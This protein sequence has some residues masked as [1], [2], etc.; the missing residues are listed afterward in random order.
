MNNVAAPTEAANHHAGE[1]DQKIDPSIATAITTGAGDHSQQASGN[2]A[3]AYTTAPG[4]G[5]ASSGPV[6]A[7]AEKSP[8]VPTTTTTTTT[9]ITTTTGAPNDESHSSPIPGTAPT[10]PIVGDSSIASGGGAG[11]GSNLTAAALPVNAGSPTT[12]NGSVV[13]PVEAQ[14]T[15]AISNGSA[16]PNANGTNGTNQAEHSAVPAAAAAAGAGAA[17]GAAAA[18]HSQEKSQPEMVMKPKEAKQYTK[19]LR[20][21]AKNDEKDLAKAIKDAQNL[22]KPLRKANKAEKQSEKRHQSAVHDEHKASKAFNKYKLEYEKAQ[23]AL[24]K[25]LDELDIKK[26]HTHATQE[27]FDKAKQRIDSLRNQ[28]IVNDKDRAR[29]QASITATE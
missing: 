15:S 13:S 5:E 4:T 23:A 18:Q 21:E 19:L 22:E 24:Q 10:S 7:S 2:A 27:A 11:P 25:S 8:E 29:R 14:P 20:K 16:V 12:N 17:G 6:Q 1:V 26:K 9:I 3:P 28:K